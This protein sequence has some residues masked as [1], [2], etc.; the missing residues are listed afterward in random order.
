MISRIAY[1]TKLQ[2]SMKNLLLEIH[3]VTKTRAFDQ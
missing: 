3:S 2:K 1:E